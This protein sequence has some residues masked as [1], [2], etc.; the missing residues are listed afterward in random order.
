VNCME[1]NFRKLAYVTW[2]MILWRHNY[3]WRMYNPCD[4]QIPYGLYHAFKSWYQ[5]EVIRYSILQFRL[6]KS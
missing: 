3:E 6:S 4:Q 2:G 5:L 1:L